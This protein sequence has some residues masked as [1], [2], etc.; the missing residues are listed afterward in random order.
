MD[1]RPK[2]KAV[3][4]TAALAAGTPSTD[5]DEKIVPPFILKLM[6]MINDTANDHM[7][8]WNPTG[9]SIIVHDSNALGREVLP[10]YYKHSNFTSLVRQLN[11]Y[12]FHKVIGVEQGGLKQQDQQYWEFSHPHVQRDHP[13]L[14]HFVKR[15]DQEKTSKKKLQLQDVDSVLVDLNALRAQ[16]EY[17]NS[18]FREMEL[19]NQV[20]YNEV[21]Q[22]RQQQADQQ[23]KVAKIMEFLA[24]YVKE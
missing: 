4:E 18:R 7:I 15:K 19:Q 20:L 2:R 17:V 24:R 6:A 23:W 14:L 9:S 1:R 3:L 12:G 16:H 13:E 8:I 10:K 21:V 11:M 5:E 22:L